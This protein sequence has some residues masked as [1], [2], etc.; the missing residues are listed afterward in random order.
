MTRFFS[1]LCAALCTF[2]VASAQFDAPLTANQWV[3]PTEAGTLVGRI[4]LPSGDGMAGAVEGASVTITSVDG[5][6]VSGQAVTDETGEFTIS[7]VSP[8]VYALK[9]RAE[10]AYVHTAIHVIDSATD[11]GGRFPNV[12]ETASTNMSYSAVNGTLVRYQPPSSN[13]VITMANAD[14]DALADRIINGETFR[15][16]QFDGG[17]NGRLYVAG[18]EGPNLIPA[19]MTNVFIMRNGVE[20]GR[21]VTN[22]MG[23]FRIDTL[24]L[25]TYSLLAIGRDGMAAVGFDLVAQAGPDV[26]RRT[27]DGKR[28]VS[29]LKAA[30]AF[31]C[32]L[33]PF[34]DEEEIE[35][36]PED[37]GIV[38]GPP[39][40]GIID[41][42]DTMTGTDF[43]GGNIVGGGGGGGFGNISG[44]PAAFIVTAAILADDDDAPGDPIS[45]PPPATP[46]VP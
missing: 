23:E 15:V 28:L 36:V 37:E 6:G 18:A 2:T 4:I 5:G 35:V 1:A 16:S 42:F 30:D 19:P 11:L 33:V 43:S 31:G 38:I 27:A 26:A 8:G 7:G 46:I 39:I 32:H 9:A 41:G 21:A 13:R 3:Q 40:D 14:L 10:N 25:G 20:V 34:T 24:D 12:A 17:L 44:L 45:A 29:A 22:E